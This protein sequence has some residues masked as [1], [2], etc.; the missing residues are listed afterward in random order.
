MITSELYFLQLAQWS[1]GMIPA[2]GVG[3]PGFKFRL[4]P[5]V[6]Q[7]GIK[8]HNGKESKHT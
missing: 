2:L 8:T 7:Q 3:G 5:S 4:S 6:F 1:R